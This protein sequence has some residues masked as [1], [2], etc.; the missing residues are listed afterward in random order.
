MAKAW[1]RFKRPSQPANDALSAADKPVTPG[2]DIERA[3]SA[4]ADEL[5]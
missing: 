3:L 4:F 2:E 5:G 1:F